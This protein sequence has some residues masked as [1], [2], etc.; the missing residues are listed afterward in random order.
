VASPKNFLAAGD[1]KM[2]PGLLEYILKVVHIKS[3]IHDWIWNLDQR[4]LKILAD[5]DYG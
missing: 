3:L 4:I 5:Y 1:E 2:H